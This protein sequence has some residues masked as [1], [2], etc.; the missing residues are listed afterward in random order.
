MSTICAVAT[1]QGGAIGIVRTSGPEAIDFTDSIFKGKHSLKDAPSHT[2]VLGTIVD[3]E[4]LVDEVLVS[5]YRSPHSYTGEDSTEIAC[6]ASEYILQK[7]V[8]LLIDKGCRLARPGEFTQRAFLNGR[9][10]LSQAEAVADVIASTTASAHRAAFSQLRG[11]YSLKLRELRDKLIEMTS[12]LELELDF[13]EEDV[14]FAE[15]SRLSSLARE[16]AD[17]TARLTHS[18]RKGNAIKNGVPVAIVGATNVGK[19]T[20]LNALLGDD[21]S[22]VSSQEGTTRDLVEDTLVI[23][24]IRFR[25]IDTA[26]IR[27]TTD[28]VEQMGIDRSF[29]A[30]EK[31][32]IILLVTQPD[33]PY[34]SIPTRADQTIIRIVNKT[35]NFSALNGKGIGDLKQQLV[36]AVAGEE[37]DILVTN[38]RHYEALSLAHT[39]IQRAIQ[40]IETNQ[41]ADIVAEDLR[42]CSAQLGD[43]LGEITPSEVLE[44]IFSHFCIGK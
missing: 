11:G 3:G 8:E 39:S 30:V 32:Q 36:E 29:Q 37:S 38:L 24:D 13:S 41:P 17:E 7:I 28:S 12:L 43:I 27:S 19:S 14:E 33:I 10:D 44:N 23:N 6:H 2:I 15:R 31:A 21:R 35:D 18:F 34:P 25:F 9:M 1:G 4:E 22:I 26:G 40:N 42:A 16:L 20:L 5:I